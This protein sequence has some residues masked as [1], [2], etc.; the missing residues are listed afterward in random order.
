MS[1]IIDVQELHHFA[2]AVVQAGAYISKSE[3]GFARYLELYQEHRGALLEEYR[4]HP[5]KI[6]SYEWTVYTTWTISFEQLS[7]QASTFLN[8]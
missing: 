7:L 2:L 8:V 6:D 3:C 1:L 5:Q 4:N